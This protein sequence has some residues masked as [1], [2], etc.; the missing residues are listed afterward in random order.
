MFNALAGAWFRTFGGRPAFQVYGKARSEKDWRIVEVLAT[1]RRD[2]SSTWPAPF[3]RGTCITWCSTVVSVGWDFAES[4][5]Q[6]QMLCPASRELPVEV[7]GGRLRSPGR[8]SHLRASEILAHECGHT[9]QARRLSMLYLPTGAM[10]TLF[11][12]G[13]RWWN[14]FEN[15]ASAQGLFGGIVKGSLHP[16]LAEKLF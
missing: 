9:L 10:F 3:F 6:E 12:E 1:S 13:N 15:H 4:V 5:L 7:E 14:H 11:R 8:T 16:R 2:M